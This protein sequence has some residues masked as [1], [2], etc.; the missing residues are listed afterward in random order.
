[1]ATSSITLVQ[2]PNN[3]KGFLILIPIYNGLPTT[4]SNRQKNIK[5]FIVGVFRIGDI[6]RTAFKW[7]PTA[8]INAKLIDITNN[9]N[10]LLYEKNI[11][12]IVDQDFLNKLSYTK[13]LKPFNGRNW[14]VIATPTLEYIESRHSH[15]PYLLGFSSMLLVLLI[16][17]YTYHISIR[18][19]A[20]NEAQSSLEE[21]IETD[22][23]TTIS[24]RRCFDKQILIEWNRATREKSMLS[25]LMI[26]IDDFKLFN[27][28]YGH[29]RGDICLKEVAIAM[30][31]VINRSSDLIARYGGEEF[32]VILPSTEHASSIAELCR[33]AVEGLRIP[34]KGSPTSEY[35]TISVGVTSTQPKIKGEVIDLIAMADKAMY[36]AKESGRNKV[37]V[38][39]Y[40]DV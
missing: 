16:A 2:E 17:Y 14:K 22:A 10:E 4:V 13:K 27:D 33:K 15:L 18:N 1:L 34:H 19:K 31:K 11:N 37:I 26:D 3:E 6:F 36:E 40:T 35:I 39:S 38:L 30:K 8:G 23:L 29:V 9:G 7:S 24:N 5:G 25:L 21:L 28:I 20:L 12:S 32:V